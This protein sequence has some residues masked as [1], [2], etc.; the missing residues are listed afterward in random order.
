[1]KVMERHV[2]EVFPGKWA[3]LLKI[4][5]KFD[6]VESKYGFPPKKS[7]QCLSGRYP[8]DTFVIEREWES[9][10]AMETGFEKAMADPAWQALGVEMNSCLANTVIELYMPVA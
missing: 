8:L 2:C 6:A 9:M 1:M 4:E 10:A 3:E 5:K 7:Y